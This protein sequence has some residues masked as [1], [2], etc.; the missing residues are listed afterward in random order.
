MLEEKDLPNVQEIRK[1]SR[2][3][4]GSYKTAVNNII[5]GIKEA[6]EKGRYEYTYRT[7]LPITFSERLTK[8]L[9]GLGYKVEFRKF[10][11]TGDKNSLGWNIKL[12]EV[13]IKW[14]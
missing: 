10:E 8:W 11:E 14:H 13:F 9:N 5:I 7:K 12:M 6:T 1:M 3:S 4:E 2:E